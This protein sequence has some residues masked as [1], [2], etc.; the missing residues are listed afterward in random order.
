MQ[1]RRQPVVQFWGMAAPRFVRTA[2]PKKWTELGTTPQLPGAGGVQGAR[3]SV[4][5]HEGAARRWPDEA[6]CS[7]PLPQQHGRDSSR[8]PGAA[9]WAPVQRG[10]RAVTDT[11]RPSTTRFLEKRKTP[12]CFSPGIYTTSSTTICR[13]NSP[14]RRSE[15]HISGQFVKMSLDN[16]RSILYN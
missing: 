14:R 5:P 6:P 7:R 2:G 16:T 9:A 12:E 13:L 10:Q 8:A 4:Y 1:A 15:I 3:D 11:T